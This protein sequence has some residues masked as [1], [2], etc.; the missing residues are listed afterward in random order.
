MLAAVIGGALIVSSGG[1][2]RA[3]AE[4]GDRSAVAEALFQEGRALLMAGNAA[5]ACPKLAESQR[6]DPAAGTLMALALCREQVGELASAWAAFVETEGRARLDGR[7]DRERLAHDHATALRPRLSTVSL[8]VPSDLAGTPGLSIMLDG[9]ALGAGAWNVDIPID[10]GRHTVEAR[11]GG[12]PIFTAVVTVKPEGEHAR[13]DVRQAAGANDAVGSRPPTAAPPAVAATAA[14]ADTAAR[15]QA[16]ATIA[17]PGGPDGE[18]SPG[19]AQRITAVVVAAAGA[20]TVGAAVVVA[21]DAKRDYDASIGAC[22]NRV[23]PSASYDRIA[24]ARHRGDV[25]TV[26]ASIGGAAVA[27]GAVLWLLAPSPSR[28][29]AEAHGPR[30]ERIGLTAGGAM[31]AGRF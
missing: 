20:L 23:C 12:R 19:R 6:L 17:S 16:T 9:A 1:R 31:L 15:P 4:D 21:L 30:I 5:D 29:K 3:G 18:G 25:A 22:A 26:V 28:A 8:R 2:A 10:G 27:T 11:V 24:D 13:L 14:G 7:S